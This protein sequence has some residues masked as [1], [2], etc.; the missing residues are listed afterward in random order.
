MHDERAGVGA[1]QRHPRDRAVADD[2]DLVDLEA[3]LAERPSQ[4]NGSR[5]ERVGPAA[6]SG[7]GLVHRSMVDVAR[8]DIRRC[9]S[10]VARLDDG[11]LLADKTL[12]LRGVGVSSRHHRDSL[13][14]TPVCTSIAKR[15]GTPQCSTMRPSTTRATSITV[16]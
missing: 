8:G 4:P 5:G 7:E 14:R 16:K 10:E 15:S 9:E 2:E 6:A 3:D 13:S 12:R 1:M 11:K